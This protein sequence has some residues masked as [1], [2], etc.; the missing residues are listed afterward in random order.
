MK[1]KS[2]PWVSLVALLV[3][4]TV[5]VCVCA[6]CTEVAAAEN[7]T[8]TESR[9][10]IESELGNAFIDGICVITDTET[11]VQY[12][13]VDGYRCGGLTVLQSGGE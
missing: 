5:L 7:E 4:I 2:N 8:E 1:R 10:I 3:L 13:F 11:G 12:L 9:F 6:G